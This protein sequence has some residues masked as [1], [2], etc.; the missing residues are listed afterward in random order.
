[1]SQ[2]AEQVFPV[3]F[4]DAPQSFAVVLIVRIDFIR[5]V[6]V[7][8]HDRTSC[9]RYANRAEFLFQGGIAAAIVRMVTHQLPGAA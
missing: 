7:G 4:R 1:M 9:S 3:G 2:Q 8:I 5:F 6:R